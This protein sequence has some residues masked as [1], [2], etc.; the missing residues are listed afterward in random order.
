[1]VAGL[2]P[3]TARGRRDQK[4]TSASKPSILSSHPQLVDWIGGLNPWFL[5]WKTGETTPNQKREAGTGA[6]L[7]P[8]ATRLVL[9]YEA[10][11]FRLGLKGT[12]FAFPKARAQTRRL[13]RAGARAAGEGVEPRPGVVL[14]L[15]AVDGGDPFQELPAALSLAIPPKPKAGGDREV[16]K[17]RPKGEQRTNKEGNSRQSLGTEQQMVYMRISYGFANRLAETETMK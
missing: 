13:G 2:P 17:G 16:T 4:S 1:M 5:Q 14:A 15:E 12:P 10:T 7:W 11:L 9:F 6:F 8:W 3:P